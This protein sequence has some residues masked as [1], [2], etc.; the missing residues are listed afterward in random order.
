[1][2]KAPDLGNLPSSLTQS[3]AASIF[4]EVEWFALQQRAVHHRAPLLIGDE[5]GYLPLMDEGT[6]LMS[7][8]NYYSSLFG[9]IGELPDDIGS[10]IRA[11]CPQP[12]IQIAPVD[13]QSH[14]SR[15][16]VKSLRRAGYFVSSY[17]CFGN[18]YL[19]TYGITF[20]EYMA[21][22]P[23]QVRNTWQRALKR[24][25]KQASWEFKLHTAPG[26][27]LDEAIAQY[28]AI[29]NH[30]WKEPE[31]YPDFIPQLC[32]LAAYNGWLR[33]G[34]LKIDDKPVAAQIWL[35]HEDCASIFKLAYIESAS[36][37][38]PGTVLTATMMK[39][40][41]DID[42][43]VEV[44]Y[45]TGD[46]RYKRDWMTHRRERHGIIATRLTTWIGLKTAARHLLGRLYRR[47][48]VTLKPH[49]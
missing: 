18:W 28:E 30:S 10:R 6:H 19:P 22:R 38:S 20:D 5:G 1:M 16:L 17:F 39:H 13:R 7:Y 47:V 33:L 11:R 41:L 24:L 31:P 43:V 34:L 26:P 37:F 25:D 23:S 27:A 8:C 4:Q 32:H 2:S 9:P 46:E 44:D 21:Q 12:I 40:V 45:L 3:A 49:R 15:Q 48:R 36:H 35:V 14:W 42:R 29:Y